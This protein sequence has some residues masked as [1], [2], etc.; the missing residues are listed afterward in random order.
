M[1]PTDY[2][3]LQI[4]G[5][6]VYIGQ[7]RVKGG[8]KVREGFGVQILFSPD[9]SQRTPLLSYKGDWENDKMHGQGILKMPE[10]EY[11]G[12]FYEGEANGS[13]TYKFANG[14]FYS[15]GF[16]DGM[17]NGEGTYFTTKGDSV[18]G[19]FVK[20][21]VLEEGIPLPPF[22]SDQERKALFSRI[23]EGRVNPPIS[24]E[25]P[26]PT[27]ISSGESL[28]ELISDAVKMRRVVLLLRSKTF[29]GDLETILQALDRKKAQ[30]LFYSAP[31]LTDDNNMV[32]FLFGMREAMETGLLL[33]INVDFQTKER[34]KDALPSYVLLDK[35]IKTGVLNRDSQDIISSFE[36]F[37]LEP[38]GLIHPDF[39]F[40]LVGAF[41]VDE[42]DSEASNRISREYKWAKYIGKL[43]LG[44]LNDLKKP[45]PLYQT[46]LIEESVNFLN[47][48]S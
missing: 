37:R 30:F 40:V 25:L 42:K 17:P 33:L 7:T 21:L 19:T 22:I 10:E 29:K 12:E 26:S 16:V 4:N 41:R 43:A 15:G 32:E 11:Q 14:D 1:L 9:D 36:K 27:P 35:V 28:V 18:D 45:E 5:S 20:G 38:P 13:G 46:E 31:D 48:N 24:D 8:K 34:Q 6:T 47:V 23:F 39:C 3:S 44:V 2:E